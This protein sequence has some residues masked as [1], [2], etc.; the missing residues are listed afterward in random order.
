MTRAALFFL[1]LVPAMA[2]DQSTLT[3]KLNG[4][5]ISLPP[6]PADAGVKKNAKGAAAPQVVR[7][8]F[9][10]VGGNQ[11]MPIF[12]TINSAAA[13]SDLAPGDPPIL[14]WKN[15]ET[16]R[17]EIAAASPGDVTWKTPLFADPLQ[18][19]WD[20]V[21]RI[22]WPAVPVPPTGPFSIALRD[23]SFI[24]GDVVDVGAETLSIH[25]TRDGDAVLKRSEV[26][27]V[28][29]L[30][31]GRNLTYCGPTGDVGWKALTNQQDG[32]VNTNSFG[33]EFAPA[34]TTG[35]GGA[36]WI[37][38]WNRSGRLDLTLPDSVEVD[39]SLSTLER[40][41]FLLALGGNPRATLRIET[42]DDQLVVALGEDFQ[43]IR[44]IGDD[45]RRLALRVYWDKVAQRCL[46]VNAAGG[47]ITEWHVPRSLS[48]TA[49]GLVLEN[50]GLNLSLDYLC[51]RQ[52]D[53]KPPPKIDLKQ[54]Q[55][56]LADGRCLTG[57]LVAGAPG[58]VH[59]QQAG[60][61]AVVDVPMA[62]L[63]A[64]QFS[65]DPPQVPDHEATFLYNDGSILYGSLESV[66]N[67]RASVATYFTTKPLSSQL[68]ALRQMVVRV[69]A[70]AGT[71]PEKPLANLDKIVVGQTTLH[72]LLGTAGNN[73]V[74][75][76]PVGGVKAS[77]PSL[78][79][80]SAI[81]RFF[82]LDAPASGDSALFYM[83]SGDVLPGN[84]GSLDRTGAEFNS[85]LMAARRI[86][87]MELN[88]IKFGP[89]TQLKVDGFKD[90][91]WQI[92][93]G[94][95]TKVHRDDDGLRLDPGAAVGFASLMQSS[96][97]SFKFISNG[98]SA[99]RLRMFTSKTDSA[100][101]INLL[102]GSTGNQF[103]S[104]LESTQGQFD[105]QVQIRTNPGDPVNVRLEIGE[106]QVELFVNDVSQLHIPIDPAK[107]A[108]SGLVIEPAGL[109][110]NNSFSVSL[111]G[112]A[113]HTGPGRTWLPDVS[114]D[115]RNQVL[116]VP[117]F[118]KDDPPPHLLLAGNDDVLR[119]EITA[120]T[121]E[122]F[123]FRCGLENLSVP[124]ERVG[125]VIWLKPAEANPVAVA[126]PVDKPAASSLDQ[127]IPGRIMF[128]QV[129]LTQLVSFSRVAG[130]GFENHAA[131]DG[132]TS[133]GP[134]VVCQP[135]GE[136]SPGRDLLAV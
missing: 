76:V 88:A 9:Q 59:L 5:H 38:S 20:A 14:R 15:G 39:F 73:S 74:G 110:G 93:R 51:V 113:A 46:V 124:R 109:W 117:R 30:R 121:A 97:I 86:P 47:L 125:A 72:G 95:E 52:W 22:D 26:L 42:W 75:W 66:S 67:G 41:D 43:V 50:K 44:K 90:P 33:T 61:T 7:Q 2:D 53:G 16:L 69:P 99:A 32:S 3:F 85:S 63:D 62:N 136:R 102:L 83:T 78:S 40:P 57:T 101:G 24:Y 36:L 8:V 122:H 48:S 31:N 17:G 6:T 12:S 82:P 127:R 54:M 13:Q 91:G 135:D 131:A 4:S 106:D 116:T 114:D 56:E 92:V 107:R 77:R 103:L 65:G 96:E 55:V 27:S 11:L 123:G 71:P 104:G 18:L 10:V 49:P 111:A 100:R 25:S 58:G 126:P 120:A 129:G 80:P 68:D 21:D 119:G 45:E 132:R 23:G 130:A 87:A 115:V 29:R 60:Q 81:T 112:F 84:L 128:R 108:G 94:D 64:L 105:N 28:R 1:L 133:H 37:S 19:R 98:L 34:L 134:D 79:Q 35:P 89:T 70:P 118:Q